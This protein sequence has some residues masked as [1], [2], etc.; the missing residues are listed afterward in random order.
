MRLE[1]LS[2]RPVMSCTI[3]H[4]NAKAVHATPR[5]PVAPVLAPGPGAG[6]TFTYHTPRILIHSPHKRQGSRDKRERTH[7]HKSQRSTVTRWYG[8][9]YKGGAVVELT[10]TLPSPHARPR[11]RGKAKGVVLASGRHR[12]T[13]HTQS[14]THG[15]SFTSKTFIR[16]SK[17]YAGRGG[18]ARA[19]RRSSERTHDTRAAST[20]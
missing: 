3:S 10:V 9:N 16:P 8:Y 19:G 18:A 14:Q 4:L 17:A 6:H 15:D 7:A 11:H 20:Q 5:R 2:E 1:S 12:P 13:G